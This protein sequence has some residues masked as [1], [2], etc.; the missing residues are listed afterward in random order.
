MKYGV[1]GVGRM[2]RVHAG[3]VKDLDSEICCIGDDEKGAIDIALKELPP[4]CSFYL[5]TG[6]M[7]DNHPELEA[8]VIASHTKDHPR[9][10]LPFIHSGIPVYLEKPLTDDLTK[11]F[12]FVAEIGTGNNVLQIGLQRRFDDA[13]CY[14]KEIIDED[15]LGEI[16][17]IRS[18]LRDQHPPPPTYNSRGLIIDMGIHVAD[19]VIWLTGEFPCSVWARLLEAR[20]YESPIDEGGNTAFVGF[21]TPGGIIGRLDLSRTHSS[22]YNNET[23]II[24]EYGT[25]HVG[26][27]CGYPGPIPVELWTREGKLHERSKIFEMS[28]PEG[29]YP[30]FLPRFKKTFLN[31]H[32][33]FQSVV[34]NNDPFRVTQNDVLKA[35]VFVEAAHRSALNG[36]RLY[37]ISYSPDLEKFRSIC[38]ENKL[39]D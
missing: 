29:D 31:A 22:G 19:E 6:E 20:H 23:Y 10:A 25:L 12:D 17:E 13:L 2:G 38:Y 18:V 36:G 9:H 27:F 1:Y 24:G 14:A 30:E 15:L 11:A 21:K 39:L 16:K 26:R 32:K 5:D 34:R 4:G 35:Q 28:Y 37:E 7:I 8:V 33:H 3:L